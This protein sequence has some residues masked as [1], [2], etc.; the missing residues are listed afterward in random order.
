MLHELKTS[1]KNAGETFN[2]LV[3]NNGECLVLNYHGVVESIT[4]PRLERNFHGASA[5]ISHLKF[6]KKY[7][8]VI[9]LDELMQ[10]ID[11]RQSLKN[12]VVLTFDDGYRNNI[13]AKELADRTFKTQVPI[14]IFVSANCVDS[15]RRSIWTVNLSLLLLRGGISQLEFGGKFFSMNTESER[16]VAFNSVRNDLKQKDGIAR[17]QLLDSIIEQYDSNELEMLVDKYPQFKMMNW[18]ECRQL[19]S[20]GCNIESHGLEHEVQNS[21]QTREILT[22]EIIKSKEIISQN[23]GKEVLSFSYP[24]GNFSEMSIGILKNSGYKIAFTTRSGVLSERAYD[25]P[26]LIPRIQPASKLSSFIRGIVEA[27]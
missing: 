4:S 26:Y 9:S 17:Q 3:K 25:E 15:E 23:T 10:A 19:I 13:Y 1:I 24:N 2:Y 20:G 14:T 7:K 6:L 11:T 12:C 18:D 22:D 21:E 8:K 5:F 16:N 27:Q